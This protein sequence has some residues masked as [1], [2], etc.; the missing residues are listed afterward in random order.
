MLEWVQ[1]PVREVAILRVKRAGQNMSRTCRGMSGGRYTQS[2]SAGGRTGTVRMP[3]G[4]TGL[5]AHWRHLANAIK[6]SACGGDAMRPYVELLGPPVRQ[7]EAAEIGVNE[8]R[9]TYE[10]KKCTEQRH[11]HFHVKILRN[12]KHTR[13]LTELHLLTLMITFETR[14]E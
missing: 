4:C 13:R 14:L 5:G 11:F 10:K 2:D 7:G 1:I 9:Y 6:L 12:C 3:I 8:R